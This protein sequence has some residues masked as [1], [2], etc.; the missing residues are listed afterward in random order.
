MQ[1]NQSVGREV[2]RLFKVN[3]KWPRDIRKNIQPQETLVK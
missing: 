2:K 3:Y 1:L